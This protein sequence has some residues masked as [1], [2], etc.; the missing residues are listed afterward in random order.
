MTE[1]EATEM[2]VD[3]RINLVLATGGEYHYE[4]QFKVPPTR[5][6]AP[7]DDAAATQPAR[8]VPFSSSAGNSPGLARQV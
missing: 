8:L 3:V 4:Q 5:D 1:K 6:E 7:R 2:A